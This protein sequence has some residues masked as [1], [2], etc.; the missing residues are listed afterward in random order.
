MISDS[1]PFV[2]CMLFFAFLATLSVSLGV[3]LFLVWIV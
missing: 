1:A 2:R 3:P